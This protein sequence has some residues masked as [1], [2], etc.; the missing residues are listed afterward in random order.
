MSL[1][2]RLQG[3]LFKLVVFGGSEPV[4]GP[5]ELLVWL[6]LSVDSP[7][8]PLACSGVFFFPQQA[9]HLVLSTLTTKTPQHHFKQMHTTKISA[10]IPVKI[11][12]IMKSVWLYSGTPPGLE[13]GVV[14]D[15]GTTVEEEPQSWTWTFL[16]YGLM[17]LERG[18][19]KPE[20]GVQALM[21]SHVPS[22]SALSAVISYTKV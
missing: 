20:D 8:S 21:Q 6:F 9:A 22:W 5:E 4:P 3:H 19:I 11:T 13:D 16:Q 7:V 10:A 1:N 12:K 2:Y 15:T 18:Y 14:V 17:Y